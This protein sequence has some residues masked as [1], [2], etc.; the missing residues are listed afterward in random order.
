MLSTIHASPRS[1]YESI[2][3]VDPG[4][5]DDL[6]IGGRL[7][8][9]DQLAAGRRSIGVDDRD[10]NV[11]HVGRR[12]VAEDVELDDRREDDDAEQPR[13]LAQLQ[14]LLLHQMKDA[15]RMAYAHS[16]RSRS[17]ARPEATV[18]KIASAIMSCQNA[19]MSAPFST[20]AR[21]ATRK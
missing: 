13:I 7:E 15:S 9:M 11:L 10:R 6:E 12:R 16:L 14:Q 1:R 17:D 5:A 19:V 18:A 21:S 8:S 3:L 4:I 2:S 20:I